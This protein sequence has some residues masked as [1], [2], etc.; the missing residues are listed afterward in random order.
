VVLEVEAISGLAVRYASALYDIAED[1][2]NIDQVLVDLEDFLD[3]L[4]KSTAFARFISSPVL[5]RAQQKAGISAI[6]EKAALSTLTS[7]FLGL[8]ALNNRLVALP[9]MITAFQRLVAERRGE[10]S[11]EVISA[12]GLST[13]QAESLASALQKMTGSEVAITNKIDNSILGGIVVKIGSRMIDSS[14]KSKLQ[15]LKLSMKGVG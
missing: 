15:R 8:V 9:A 10:V 12:I 4:A 1:Q 13:V 5:S 3:L 14:L 11:A 7:N 2:D 6:A